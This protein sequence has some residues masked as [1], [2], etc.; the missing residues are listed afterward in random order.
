MAFDILFDLDG[1]K[2][3]NKS[4]FKLKIKNINI[5]SESIK[6]FEDN[7]EHI[8]IEKMIS[9]FMMVRVNESGDLF[10]I[11][12]SVSNIL[13]KKKTNI[14][15]YIFSSKIKVDNKLLGKRFLDRKNWVK[16]LISKQNYNVEKMSNEFL[17]RN[18]PEYAVGHGVAVTWR[19]EDGN[20][21]LETNF[22]PSNEIRP[23]VPRTLEDD[24]IIEMEHLSK[25][26]NVNDLKT[27][28][29]GYQDWIEDLKIKQSELDEEYEEISKLHLR[30]IEKVRSRIIETINLL[31]DN[32]NAF[33][34]F[35]LMNE[36]MYI[37]R[38]YSMIKDNRPSWRPFQLAFI[39]F[40]LGGIIDEDSDSRK[41]VDLLWFPTGGGK[42]EAYLGLMAFTLILEG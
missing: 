28:I 22:I 38:K 2:P 25:I 17:N 10:M 9:G 15:D 20:Q 33:V 35:K 6:N 21:H 34:S 32:N 37:M 36:A 12:F 29:E 19:Y 31:N 23:I 42:T 27:F 11:T 7:F 8:D 24:S 30:K 41:E 26:E 16:G 3:K 4:D 14:E 13:E 18:I 39:L 1:I 5:D 40:S